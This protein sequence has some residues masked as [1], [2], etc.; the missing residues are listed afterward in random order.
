MY[1]RV[2]PLEALDV[3]PL[4]LDVP[5]ERGEEAREVVVRAR[6]DPDAGGLARRARHLGAELGGHAPLLLPVAARDADEARVVRVVLE[7][8]LEWAQALEQRADLGVDEPLV[9]DAPERRERLGACR[10]VPSGVVTV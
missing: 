5:L 10:V 7:R 2:V 6:L 1:G 9:G 8:L 3:A 4:Q